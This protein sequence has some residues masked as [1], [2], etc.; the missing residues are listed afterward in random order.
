M[1]QTCYW[2]D[3]SAADSSQVPC[4]DSTTPGT[5]PS[6]CAAGHYCFSGGVCL[7]TEFMTL[8]RGSCTDKTWQSAECY[9]YCENLCPSGSC[10]LWPCNNGPDGS[11]N[12]FGCTNASCG[13][14]D[15]VI[16]PAG[17]ILR[18]SA[19]ISDLSITSSATQTSSTTSSS[20]ASTTPS[21]I[22]T[23]VSDCKSTGEVAGVGA[24][25][26]IP[27]LLALIVALLL[28]FRTRQW[29]R[30]G[31]T[32]ACKHQ[33]YRQDAFVPNTYSAEWL[34]N[35]GPHQDVRGQNG[36]AAWMQPSPDMGLHELPN[37]AA[38]SRRPE[39]DA[40]HQP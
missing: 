18:N 4:S 36:S 24:G 2:P 19:I 34:R 29:M 10:A 25:I 22:T 13:T 40:S 7:N 12:H 1:A 6:C 9:G 8:Y 35:G 31:M 11:S 5:Y 15:E 30:K 21:S 23:T 16:V 38:Q 37:T 27:L 39:L 3:N 33:H 14:Q 20:T 17:T 32:V 28:L 26:G